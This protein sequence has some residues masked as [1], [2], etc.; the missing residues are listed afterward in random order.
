[1][2][3]TT[4]KMSK[5]YKIMWDNGNACGDF[6]HTFDTKKAAEQF[7]RKWKREMVAL[8]ENPKEARASYSWDVFAAGSH[9][10]PVHDC[11]DCME[12][13]AHASRN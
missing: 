4:N 10:S 6:P 9:G 5:Q 2:S 1:M 8:D 12:T 3:N 13:I 7:A 11:N